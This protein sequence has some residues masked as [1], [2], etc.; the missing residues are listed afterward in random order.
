MNLYLIKKIS[1]FKLSKSKIQLGTRVC[2]VNLKMQPKMYAKLQVVYKNTH[3]H[4]KT[5]IVCFHMKSP[6]C[7]LLHAVVRDE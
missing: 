2:R 1:G 5:G 6:A 3:F 7:I 4:K